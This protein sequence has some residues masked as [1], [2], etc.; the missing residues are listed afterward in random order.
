M[1]ID[2][3]INTKVNNNHKI[4]SLKT[5]SKNV[6]SND[7]FYAIK[8]SISDGNKYI[9]DAIKLG[10]K[11]IISE[12]AF[13]DANNYQEINFIIVEDIRKTLAV[14]AKVFYQDISKSMTLIGVTGTN[15]KTTVTTLLYKYFQ[16]LNKKATLIG[17]NGIY[18]MNTFY[19]TKNTTPD[20]LE[21][22]EILMRSKKNGVNTVFM[23]VSS[24]AVKMMRIYGLH[25]KIALITNLTQDH[26][27]FHKNMDDYRYSKGL[28]LNSISPDNTVIIN[29]DIEDFRFFYY[30]S[31]AKVL[32]YG[33]NPSNYH[34]IDYKLTIEGSSFIVS[35]NNKVYQ[36]QTKLLGLFNIYN[37]LSFI[38]IIDQLGLFNEKAIE[39]INSKINILGRME[40][41]KNKNRYFVIDFAH[42]PDGVLN[43]LDFLGSVKKEGNLIVVAGCG[44]DRDTSKRRVIGDIISRKCNFAFFTNDNP[45]TEDPEKIIKDILEG[46]KSNNYAV[47]LDRKMAIEEAYKRSLNEDIIAILGKGNEQYQII[48]TEKIKFSDKE[49][50][51]NLN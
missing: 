30:L 38:S 3:L 45:R 10:A 44:G 2:K 22:Y 19:E 14:H 42:T 8:G 35:I 23:E 36:M 48:N 21:L 31:N 17:T 29:K 39:F 20:I 1:K 13:N 37:I 24:H 4:N 32:T 11:T 25:F 7:I 16:L 15:G 12:E 43:V 34:L 6:K 49:I 27:D 9:K 50:V 28:F 51:Q 33:I 47:I 46:V 5:N 41:I 40:V 18:I 26:L